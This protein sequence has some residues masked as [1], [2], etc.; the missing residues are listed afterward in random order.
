M[1]R[2]RTTDERQV[3]PQVLGRFAEV[4]GGDLITGSNALIEIGYRLAPMDLIEAGQYLRLPR[5]LNNTAIA[6]LIAAA[7]DGKA[8]V[9]DDRAKKAVAELTR[10]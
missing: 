8:L 10:D 6:A 4:H 7:T 1:E 9:E 2:V 5:A 3:V